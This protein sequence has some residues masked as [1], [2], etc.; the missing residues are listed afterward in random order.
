MKTTDNHRREERVTKVAAVVGDEMP[1]NDCT[2]LWDIKDV[3]A[4]L[5]VPVG[6]LYQWR[7]RGDGPPA[8]RLG[9]HLRFDPAAVRRWAGSHQGL[10]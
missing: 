10:A 6:T 4:F 5:L 8:M 9:R 1:G 7:V 2:R 3:S